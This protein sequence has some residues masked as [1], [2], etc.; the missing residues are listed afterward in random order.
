MLSEACWTIGLAVADLGSQ[1]L[2][3]RV[4]HRLTA[5]HS[6]YAANETLAILR[7]RRRMCGSVR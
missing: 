4:A 2:A 6:T 3:F 5:S 1:P 7:V